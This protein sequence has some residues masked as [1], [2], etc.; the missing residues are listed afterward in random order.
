M[1]T[2]FNPCGGRSES[3]YGIELVEHDGFFYEPVILGGVMN[4]Y[5]QFTAREDDVFVCSG[6]K[7]GTTWVKAIVASI[8][9]KSKGNVLK[10]GNAHEL[11]PHLE[12]SYD[13]R[14]LLNA[15]SVFQEMP[16]PRLFG[17]HLPYSALPPQ[18]TSLGCRIIYIVRNPRDTFVSHWKFL[19]ALQT[20]FNG[21]TTGPVSKEVFFDSFCNG[22]SFYGPFVDH[23]L[24][25]WKPSRNQ[26]NILFLTYEDM[27]ADSLYHIKKISDFLG[28][29]SLT[30]EDIRCIDSQ[31]S[32]QSPSTLD[33]NTSG[34]LNFKNVQL[35]NRELFR[36]GEV[37]DWKNHFTP[38]MNRRMVL[39]VENKFQEAGLFVK[40][41]L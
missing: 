23:V 25:Y 28:Q 29:C 14:S 24:S 19:P 27:K 34:K 9:S 13:S 10:G 3:P 18:V 31:C 35:N 41:E 33:V 16:S 37:G 7:T 17:T 6:V 20:L 38:E 4:M 21:E 8:M 39:V 12:V 2:P 15:S 11:I 30:E 32:F 26:S 22:V 40:Y 5:T 1:S 36:K